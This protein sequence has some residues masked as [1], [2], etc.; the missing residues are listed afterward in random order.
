MTIEKT[1]IPD[2]DRSGFLPGFLGLNGFR[3]EMLAYHF[4]D[5]YCET[6]RGGY[7]HFY[8]L[9]NGGMFICPDSADPFRVVNEVNTCDTV[10]SAEAA[11]IGVTLYAL[12][13]LCFGPHDDRLVEL[14]HALREFA[15]E[16]P[17]GRGIFAFID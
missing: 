6:Y 12:N 10:L 3:F 14:Y 17:E 16:H 9:S 11:G 15:A 1:L 8:A 5:Q 2:A 4:M 13:A 7:W